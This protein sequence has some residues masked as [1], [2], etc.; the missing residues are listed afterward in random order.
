M[1]MYRKLFKVFLAR[2]HVAGLITFDERQKIKYSLDCL[3]FL[4]WSMEFGV[5]CLKVS[6]YMKTLFNFW[7]HRVK[8]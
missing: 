5:K 6:V 3:V 4:L 8:L 7:F 2:T 1:C